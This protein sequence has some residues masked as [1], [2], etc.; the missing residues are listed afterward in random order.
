MCM[1]YFNKNANLK[2]KGSWHSHQQLLHALH[3]I[4]TVVN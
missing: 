4:F 3:I 1:L 2:K